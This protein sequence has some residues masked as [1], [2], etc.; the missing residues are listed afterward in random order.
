MRKNPWRWAAVQSTR[1]PSDICRQS[2][3]IGSDELPPGSL[4]AAT[5]RKHNSAVY[6]AVPAVND[7]RAVFIDDF[8][9][10]RSLSVKTTNGRV[11]ETFIT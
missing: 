4:S 10:C 8:E 1:R 11:D 9:L 6:A 5:V 3:Q 2:M 7:L